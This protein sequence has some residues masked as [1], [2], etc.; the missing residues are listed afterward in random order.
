[1]AAILII[2]DE[3]ELARVVQSYLEQA[4]MRVRVEDRGDRGLWAWEQLKPDLVLLDLNLPGMDGLDVAREIRRKSDTPIIMVTA[5]AEE[6]D[7][8]IGLELGAD[9]Y[10]TKPFSPREVVA[11][12]RAVLRRAGQ[13]PSAARHV[14]E[15]DLEIDLDSHVARRAGLPLELTPTEFNLLTALASQ[16][17]R[18]FTRLQLLEA[19]QGQ[20]YEGYERTVDAHI[21]N[22]RS[23]LELDPHQPRYIETVFGV[24]YRF[25]KD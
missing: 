9:D 25:R 16:P 8:L 14:Q 3:H 17:G 5:R 1:M 4:G 15:G 12:V 7:R 21:K 2:E 19:S 11:R 10:I 13:G 23:K 22:L 18:V 24:G 20:A 6:T